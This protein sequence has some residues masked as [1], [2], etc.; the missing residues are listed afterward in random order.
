VPDVKIYP[1]FVGCTYEDAVSQKIVNHLNVMVDPLSEAS[2]LI[3]DGS[4]VAVLTVPALMPPHRS[5][6][7]VDESHGRRSPVTDLRFTL[8][9]ADYDST[10]TEIR[11]DHYSDVLMQTGRS[12]AFRITYNSKPV[13]HPGSASIMLA[14]MGD[15]L[16][17]LRAT[18]STLQANGT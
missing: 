8:R 9:H 11:L 12:V 3:S 5:S 18:T 7:V 2:A 15:S 17:A 1:V 4:G 10:Q 16:G 13:D 6:M 14:R